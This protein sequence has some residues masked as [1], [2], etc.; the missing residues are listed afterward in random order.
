M[1]KSVT[2]DRVLLTLA[3]GR[4]GSVSGFCSLSGTEFLEIE[5][6]G[7]VGHVPRLMFLD[8]QPAAKTLL[9]HQKV[10]VMSK[11]DWA[12]VIK[13]VEEVDDFPPRP[14]VDR[15]G[16]TDNYFALRD[17]KVYSPARQPK[18]QLV[19]S[20]ALGGD[21]KS[22]TF[23]RWMK[24]IAEPLAGQSLPMVAVLAAMAAPLLRHSGLTHNPGLELCGPRGKGKTLLLRLAIS[25]ADNPNKLPTFDATRIGLSKISENYEDRI[26]PVDEGSHVDRADGHFFQSFVFG[27][28]SGTSRLTAFQTEIY[29]SR[30]ILMT[31]ANRSYHESLSHL[32][33]ETRAA[34]LD[35]LLPLSVDPDNELG[36][37]DFLPEGFTTSGEFA[38][39][40]EQAMNALFGVAMRRLLHSIVNT[41]A[42]DPAS[43]VASLG[44]DI[45]AFET[46]V[47]VASSPQGRTRPSSSFG[48]FYAAGA[49]AQRRGILPET[50][51]CMAACVAAFRN[52]QAQLPECTPLAARLM[53]I[54]D[55]PQTLDL[56]YA[57]TPRMPDEE[58][59]AHGAFV[60]RG[61]NGRTEL[62]ITD[63]IVDRYFPD[64]RS[65]SGSTEFKNLNLRDRDHRTKQRQVRKSHKKE[66]LVCF[67]LPTDLVKQIDGDQTA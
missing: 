40:L 62:L 7:A 21:A 32:D 28:A 15:L 18:A 63:D 38:R 53:M 46:A 23:A 47:G 64:W 37:F 61:K 65:L 4:S 8:Q 11:K 26:F 55:R 3:K 12:E 45:H 10:V 30:F 13:G 22:G 41:K 16:W 9:A 27:M 5:Y 49:F 59:K 17:G 50:W 67:V 34:A 57:K 43:F 14:I 56:R 1:S 52:Y 48:L 24:Q 42:K 51:D 29:E 31:T 33:H 25:V 44:A 54:V 35:R 19:S 60:K 39:N 36:V 2:I 20:T 58:F 6:G 66:R